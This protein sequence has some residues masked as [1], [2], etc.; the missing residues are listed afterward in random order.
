MERQRVIQYKCANKLNGHDL[1][2]S[3]FFTHARSTVV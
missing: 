1:T 3:F 2:K